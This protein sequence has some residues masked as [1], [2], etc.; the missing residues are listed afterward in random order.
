MDFLNGINIVWQ[1]PLVNLTEPFPTSK[2]GGFFIYVGA[3]P[4][5]CEMI[6][7]LLSSRPEIDTKSRFCYDPI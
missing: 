7:F 2:K 3:S 5:L 1:N 4:I 6:L